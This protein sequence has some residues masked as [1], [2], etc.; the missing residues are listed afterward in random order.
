MWIGVLILSYLV[1]WI[2]WMLS[3]YHF[4]ATKTFFFSI[5]WIQYLLILVRLRYTNFFMRPDSKILPAVAVET[6]WGEPMHLLRNDMNRLLVKGEP[7]LKIVSIIKWTRREHWCPRKT[8]SWINR[9]RH[10]H[11]LNATHHTLPFSAGR[12]N[13]SLGTK[14]IMMLGLFPRVLCCP[15]RWE[16]HVQTVTL[17]A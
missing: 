17:A 4:P 9:S 8:R 6:G 3:R 7:D 11:D 1:V 15:E 12:T 14:F 5:S 16:V 2:K 10:S 13:A